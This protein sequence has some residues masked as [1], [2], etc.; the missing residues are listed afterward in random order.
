MEFRETRPD[1]LS[2]PPISAHLTKRR[3]ELRTAVLRSTVNERASRTD[4]RTRQEAAVNNNTRQL[5]I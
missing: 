2:I 1:G 4:A 3:S 5:P